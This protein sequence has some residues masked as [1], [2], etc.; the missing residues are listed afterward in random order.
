MFYSIPWYVFVVSNTPKNEH[1]STCTS[2]TALDH[3]HEL[4]TTTST[5]TPAQTAAVPQQQLD[6]S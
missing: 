6:L 3:E 1:S 2:T 4:R 5:S